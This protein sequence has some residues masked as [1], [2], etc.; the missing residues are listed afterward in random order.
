[1]SQWS[2]SSCGR[3]ERLLL[4]KQLSECYLMYYD[5]RLRR[6]RFLT[7]CFGHC[8]AHDLQ[9]TRP[10]SDVWQAAA[11]RVTKDLQY[12]GHVGIEAISCTCGHYRLDVQLTLVY[13]TQATEHLFNFVFTSKK[14]RRIGNWVAVGKG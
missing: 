2:G 13:I 8:A 9:P 3:H 12:A 1:M 4:G 7:A 5:I 14:A 10:T 11:H 6:K